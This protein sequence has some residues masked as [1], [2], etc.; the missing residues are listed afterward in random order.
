[1]LRAQVALPG[2]PASMTG[3]S[4]A[5]GASPDDAERSRRGAIPQL[6]EEAGRWRDFRENHPRSEHALEAGCREAWALLRAG[7]LGDDQGRERRERLVAELR[8]DQALSVGERSQLAAFH[9]ALAVLRETGV[10]PERRCE[11]LQEA[12]R[13]LIA[14]FPG[15]PEGYESLLG[16]ACSQSDAAAGQVARELLAS[17]AAPESVKREARILTYRQTLVGRSALE[18]VASIPDLKTRFEQQRGRALLLYTWSLKDPGSV[19]QARTLAGGAPPN[20]ALIGFNLDEE[21]EAAKAAAAGAGLPGEQIYDAATTAGVLTLHAPGLV[22]AVRA[23]GRIVSISAH[24]D[25]AQTL[26]ELATP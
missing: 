15:V 26:K 13:R 18:V 12:V 8:A 11:R 20:V 2:D 7:Y 14:E 17:A 6:L 23:D 19:E 3:R 24:R 1:M 10:S 21:V 5:P 4:G 22:F 16:L 9:D 25:L